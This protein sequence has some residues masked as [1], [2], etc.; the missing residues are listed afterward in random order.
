MRFQQ[1][2]L[3]IHQTI[4]IDAENIEKRSRT[5]R[6]VRVRRIRI[7]SGSRGNG[8]EEDWELLVLTLG[9]FSAPVFFLFCCY[10]C[11]GICCGGDT[12]TRGTAETVP[13]SVLQAT[14]MPW[15]NN[16]ELFLRDYSVYFRPTTNL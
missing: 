11:I 13:D 5:K 10:C 4:K 9:I 2:F 16:H 15:Y 8:D 3:F 1:N 14:P 7:H 12:E 6:G